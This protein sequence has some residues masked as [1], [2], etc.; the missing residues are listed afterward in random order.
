M[1][2]VEFN[3]A[4]KI[5]ITLKQRRYPEGSP[6]FTQWADLDTIRKRFHKLP[7]HIAPGD[8]YLIERV[9]GDH[10]ES[11]ESLGPPPE[12]TVRQANWSK[13]LF[14]AVGPDKVQETFRAMS[15]VL[16]PDVNGGDDRRWRELKIAYDEA[17]ALE[18]RRRRR[19]NDHE[20]P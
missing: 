6:L 11:A 12:R 5:P 8:V 3:L 18:E 16:H 17:V 19:T 15:K 14:D 9:V 13:F 1:S 4:S 20:D 7:Q 10:R 2:Y